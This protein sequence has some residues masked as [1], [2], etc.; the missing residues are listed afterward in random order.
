MQSLA[1]QQ[2]EHWWYSAVK[3]TLTDRIWKAMAIRESERYRSILELST[4]LQPIHT[5]RSRLSTLRELPMFCSKTLAFQNPNSP[6]YRR[7][8]THLLTKEC[9]F[10][11]LERLHPTKEMAMNRT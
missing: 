5:K 4:W 3:A 10:L 11:R 9:A 8:T 7:R 6:C 2:K 1:I